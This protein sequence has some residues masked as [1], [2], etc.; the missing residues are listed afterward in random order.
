MKYA[1]I[2]LVA[3]SL[4]G[5]GSAAVGLDP[6]AE[7]LMKN[8]AQAADLPKQPDMKAMYGAYITLRKQYGSETAKLRGLQA[9]A[10]LVS[11]K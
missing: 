8:P 7:A 2:T 1:L 6:P 3:L 11:K 10:R 4:A 9:Y 5:C